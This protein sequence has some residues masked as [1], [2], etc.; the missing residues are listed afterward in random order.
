MWRHPDGGG[1]AGADAG[2]GAGSEFVLFLAGLLRPKPSWR[3]A[4]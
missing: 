3:I 2:A 4:S 1:D